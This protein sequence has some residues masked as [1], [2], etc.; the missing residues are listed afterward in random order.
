MKIKHIIAILCFC[1]AICGCAFAVS[2]GDITSEHWAYGYVD[3]LTTSG[4]I[5]GYP[6]G[7]F[8]PEET[9]SKAE[10]IK[11]VV[12]ASLPEEVDIADA[13]SAMDNWAGQVVAVAQIYQLIEPGSITEENMNEPITRMEMALIISKADIFLRGNSLDQSK[14]VTFND[15]DDMNR[16]EI[17]YLTHAVSKGLISGYPDNTFK[18]SKNMSRAEAATMIYRYTK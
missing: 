8:R 9:I 18:P 2:F 13:P 7:T 6:D 1:I 14:S 10:F 16:E 12:M 4:V 3:E 11:L 5:N 17:T 15:Y